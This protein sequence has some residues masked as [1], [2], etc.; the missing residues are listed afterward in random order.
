M[1]TISKQSGV[2]LGGLMIT[3]ALIG[4]LAIFAMKL[5]PAYI[6]NSK[7]QKAFDVIVHD[8][9]MEAATIREIKDSFQKRANIIDDV[10]SVNTNDI[11]ISKEGGKLK[12]SASYTKKIPLM[13]NI[14]LLIE[15]NP[16]APK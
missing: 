6:E 3:L 5:I 16:T 10:S 9:A 1:K 15:F 2:T 7:I 11:E 13:G 4:G 12:L 14:S 8:P